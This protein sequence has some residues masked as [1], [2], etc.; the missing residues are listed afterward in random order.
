MLNGAAEPVIVL[1]TPLLEL[2]P[3]LPDDVICPPSVMPALD[4]EDDAAVEIIGEP[5][6]Q[7]NKKR[8]VE[9]NMVLKMHSRYTWHQGRI[10]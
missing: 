2:A 5:N 10:C 6:I 8:N 3:A 4:D 1:G 7:E 9:K